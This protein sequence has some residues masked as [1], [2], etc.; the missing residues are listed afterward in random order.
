MKRN[1]IARRNRKKLF[2]LAF[3]F[4]FLT[5]TLFINFFHTETTLTERDDCPAC[6]FLNSTLATSQIHFFHLRSPLITGILKTSYSFH[7]IYISIIE[8]SSR[9]PPEI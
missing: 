2:N 7:Y 9:S 1:T 6:Q 8:S 4:F 5:I 3:L